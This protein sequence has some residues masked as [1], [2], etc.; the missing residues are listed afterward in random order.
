MDAVLLLLRA[1]LLIALAFTAVRVLRSSSATLRV[2]V[3]RATFVALALLP[4]ATW[5]LPAW[6]WI[7]ARQVP[8]L[9]ASAGPVAARAAEPAIESRPTPPTTERREIGAV[10]EGAVELEPR[11]RPPLGWREALLASWLLGT[12]FLLVRLGLGLRRASRLTRAAR[13]VSID[14]SRCGVA[15]VQSDAIEG[16][17]VWDPRPFGAPRIVLSSSLQEPGAA[18]WRRAALVHELWHVER[19]DGPFLIFATTIAALLWPTVLVGV[20]LERLRLETERAA[21]DAVLRSGFRPSDYAR[22]LVV[23][24][25]GGSEA[26]P[27][28]GMA[29]SPVLSQRVASVLD[30]SCNRRPTRSVQRLAT[31]TMTLILATPLAALARI[32]P[33]QELTQDLEE[34][35]SPPGDLADVPAWM[36]GRALDALVEMQDDASGAWRGDVGFKLNF[37][38]RVTSSATPHVGVTGLAVEALAAGGTKF[39]ES[40]RGQA[41]Q[42]GVEFL[43]AHQRADGYLTASGTRMRSHAY[44]TR[45]LAAALAAG[46]PARL[47]DA[48]NDAVRF[49][50]EAQST[51]TGGWRFTPEAQDSDILETAYQVDSLRSAI[52]TVHRLAPGLV[53]IPD[54]VQGR[55]GRWNEFWM[56]MRVSNPSDP[57]YGA[58][59]YQHH[60]NAR[61][62]PNTI[63]AG[64]LLGVSTGDDET[65]WE[66]TTRQLFELRRKRARTLDDAPEHFLTWDAELLVDRAIGAFVDDEIPPPVELAIE[67]RTDTLAWLAANQ[68]PDG[69]WGC[70]VGPGNAYVT[71]IG[72]ILLAR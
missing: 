56:E 67:W 38:W 22:G 71:A 14:D 51:E 23:L 69:S 58:Y 53:R 25:T 21:D 43:L 12:A 66:A 72:A 35:S 37:G 49:T 9:T 13:H 47:V 52:D 68:R 3:W 55:W 40:R 63:A 19:R 54:G 15:T 18:E 46:G 24:A 60:L 62:T 39:D 61:I 2:D 33:M 27:V 10:P 1:T 32:A 30:A 45:G 29:S 4:L 5:A 31:A 34:A 26:M 28:A 11:R 8:V 70:R 48:L 17:Y 16:A 6:R 50:L 64:I 59:K 57:R 41:L 44:A 36:R 65:E 20:A 7:P 42:R